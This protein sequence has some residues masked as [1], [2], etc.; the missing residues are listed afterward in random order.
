M[1]SFIEDFY[2]PSPEEFADAGYFATLERYGAC[3]VGGIVVCDSEHADLELL[4][5]CV[6]WYVRG[7]HFC[8]GLLVVY[9]ENGF[10][11]R[12]LMRLKNLDRGWG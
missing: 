3:D 8:V 1:D 9:A 4:R 10:R 2:S 12:C 7:D 5:A 6:T 11:N